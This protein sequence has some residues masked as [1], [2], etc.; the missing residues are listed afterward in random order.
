M[1][2]T[3]PQSQ[4]EQL[5]RDRLALDALQ[6]VKAITFVTTDGEVSALVE[7][8]VPEGGGAT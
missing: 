7:I 8:E 4:L 3:I 5:I 6:N 2:A 1:T